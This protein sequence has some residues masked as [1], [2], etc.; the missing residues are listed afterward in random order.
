MVCC[1]TCGEITIFF[2]TS[3]LRRRTWEWDAAFKCLLAI[4]LPSSCGCFLAH[5]RKG[6]KIY[7]HTQ[8]QRLMLLFIEMQTFGLDVCLL[9]Q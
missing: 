9:L 5:E 7:K 8:T 4:D 3:A 6:S 1:G 2:S